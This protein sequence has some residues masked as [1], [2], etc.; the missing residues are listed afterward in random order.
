MMHRGNVQ[1]K[2]NK[3]PQVLV[4]KST[5]VNVR[6]HLVQRTIMD[7]TKFWDYHRLARIGLS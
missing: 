3:F 5:E 7:W 4:Y 2:C 1:N 6:G